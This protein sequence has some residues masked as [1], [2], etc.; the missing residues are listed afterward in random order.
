MTMLDGDSEIHPTAIIGPAVTLGSRN[1]IGPYCVIT[2]NVVIGSGNRI[3]PFTVIGEPSRQRVR[4]RQGVIELSP[5]PSIT[6][7]DGNILGESVTIHLP[8]K[9]VTSIGSNNTIGAH[10]HV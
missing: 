10:S 4:E 5:D 1:H 6:I 7:G 2:G 3:G 8:I 9:E